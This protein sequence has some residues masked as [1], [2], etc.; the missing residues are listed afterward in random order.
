MT[1]ETPQLD[2]IPPEIFQSL[3]GKTSQEA[4]LPMVWL[5]R[6]NSEALRGVLVYAQKS[7]TQHGLT[8]GMWYPDLSP[9]GITVFP[10]YVYT[11]SVMSLS[12]R[13]SPISVSLN[14]NCLTLYWGANSLLYF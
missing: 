4:K 13:D 8:C 2:L 5:P 10:L 1:I 12:L 3:F 14:V 11:C 6:P 9:I 7:H